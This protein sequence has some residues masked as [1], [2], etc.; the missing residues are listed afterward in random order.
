MPATIPREAQEKM[1]SYNF[2]LTERYA[3][4]IVYFKLSDGYPKSS[5]ASSDT[6]P[7]SVIYSS[8][9]S[10]KVSSTINIDQKESINYNG[11]SLWYHVFNS[12]SGDLRYVIQI[13]VNGIIINKLA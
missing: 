7:I 11:G 10:L 3:P 12:S 9:E 1:I 2:I 6:T 13:N 8:D 5:D 4:D